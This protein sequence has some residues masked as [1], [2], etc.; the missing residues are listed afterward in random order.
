MKVG[1][2]FRTLQGNNYQTSA[3]SGSFAFTANLTGNPTT[4]AGTGS[5][6]ASFLLGEVANASVTTHLGESQVAKNVSAYVQ[7]DWKVSRRLTLNL[8][9][10]WDFQ[11]QPIERNNGVSNFDLSCKLPNGLSG[12]TVYAGL[13]GQPNAFRNNEYKNFGPR[14]G[15]AYDI[16]GT[17]RTVLRGG[18]GIYYPAQFWR[19]NYGNTAGFAQTSTNYNSSDANTAAFK[20]RNGFPFNPVQPQGSLLGTRGV[21]GPECQP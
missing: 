13:N 5:S 14:F 19:E 21:P 4:P 9:L 18:Y 17:S 20:L 15:F 2:D 10:R 6:Y 12:C 3:P 16:F 7:D 8:G 1:F 11:Q